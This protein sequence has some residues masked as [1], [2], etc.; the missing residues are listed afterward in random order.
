MGKV[1][2]RNAASAEESSSAAEELAG[3]SEELAA[4]VGAFQLDRKS[5][6][7]QAHP[8]TQRSE[9]APLERRSDSRGRKKTPKAAPA[10][11]SDV[12]F[13]NF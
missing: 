11:A 8:V 5:R 7:A 9:A 2:Q 10:P 3:Q 12:E 13:G 6:L 1:T 4:M